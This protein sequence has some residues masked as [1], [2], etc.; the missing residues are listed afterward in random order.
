MYYVGIDGGGTKSRLMAV[1]NAGTVFG[2]W[3]GSSTNISSNSREV[4]VQNIRELYQS[5]L[6]GLPCGPE[7]VA[8]LCIGSAGIDVPEN[9]TR[10]SEII[11]EAGIACPILV[12][13]DVEILLAGECQGSP[14]AV[15]ISG[16][17]SVAFGKNEAGLTHRTN[18]WGHLLGDEGSGYWIGQEAIR[19]CL[20]SVDQRSPPTL[21]ADLICEACGLEDISHILPSVYR[22]GANKTEI[23]NL[24][25]HVDT[26]AAQGDVAALSIMEEAAGHLFVMVESIWRVLNLNREHSIILSGG[27]VLHSKPL[28]EQL[29]PRL[30]QLSGSVR[31]V[32]QEPCMGA[33]YLAQELAKK[34]ASQGER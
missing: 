13:N 25:R 23:A 12:V 17:G 24:A 34:S 21:M 19:H 15:L 6:S 18:G 10:L 31:A 28:R 29:M 1:D 33:V 16:T 11:R 4:V 8:A 2:P 30:E 3:F 14:G 22:T 5:F 27:T 20:R 7:E 32:T 26:A 9:V